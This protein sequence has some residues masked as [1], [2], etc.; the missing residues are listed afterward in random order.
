MKNYVIMEILLNL[1]VSIFKL[2]YSRK[3][4]TKYFKFRKNFLFLLF[5]CYPFLFSLKLFVL[6]FAITRNQISKKTYFYTIKDINIT[7]SSSFINLSNANK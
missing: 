5:L 1:M 2:F 6:I 4:L 3:S 7:S